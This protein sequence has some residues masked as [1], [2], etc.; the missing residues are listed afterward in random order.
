MV[1]LDQAGLE[2]TEVLLLLPLE[3]WEERHVPPRPA[4]A[5]HVR[6]NVW[7]SHLIP[8]GHS[9]KDSQDCGA[10]KGPASVDPQKRLP[11]EACA[12]VQSLHVHSLWHK[13][14]DMEDHLQR[15]LVAEACDDG[16]GSPQDRRQRCWGHTVKKA[17]SGF[18]LKTGFFPGAL[19]SCCTS[20]NTG[21]K[22]GGRNKGRQGQGHRSGC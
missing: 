19:R 18:P 1:S 16:T 6:S 13:E 17:R 15:L 12:Q 7:H 2:F 5:K 14:E 9:R 4:G 3:C 20:V 8:A 11:G 22:C 10:K 21:D